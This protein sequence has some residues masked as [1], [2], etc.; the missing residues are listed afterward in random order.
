MEAAFSS[1]PRTTFDGVDDTVF[2]QIGVLAAKDIVAMFLF[3]C[4]EGRPTDGI[5]DHRAVLAC[6]GGEPANGGL[7][8]LA[9]DVDAHA[10]LFILFAALSIL[11]SL[12]PLC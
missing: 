11:S 9:N 6:I 8:R 7:E 12:V 1:A 10:R 3:F 5:D 4:S 2:D